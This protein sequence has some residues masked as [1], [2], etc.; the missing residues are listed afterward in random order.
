MAPYSDVLIETDNFSS[1]DIIISSV[2]LRI[3]D[4][5]KFL[6]WIGAGFGA[7]MNY[8][9]NN[10]SLLKREDPSLLMRNSRSIIVFL[11]N[12]KRRYNYDRRYGKIAKYALG[13]D[14][15]LFVI[16]IIKRYIENNHLFLDNFLAYTDTGPIS[17]K[18]ISSESGNGWIG[19]NSMFISNKI[20]SFTYL[21][22]A[23]TD[24]KIDN[25]RIPPTDLCGKCNRCI[26]SCP[27]GAINQDR[28][29][30]SRRCISYNTIENRGTIPATIASKM[31]DMLFGCDIC[32]DVCPW[33]NNSRYTEIP[34][35]VNYNYGNKAKI[36]ELAFIDKEQFTKIYRKSSI[37]RAGYLGIARNAAIAI[38]N[39]DSTD[40]ILKEIEKNFNDLRTKQI[41]ILKDQL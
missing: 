9:S 32:N 12:Y 17:E 23:I 16:N 27:T 25:F 41:K 1:E 15:H 10:S 38:Y 13:I 24:L 11:V 18:I 35:V 31:A 30:D 20:G 40:P 19:K 28:T 29:I 22:E 36:E 8:L 37:R 2:P 6:K 39:N 7:D 4:N 26:L 34:E 33:N 21:G 14:Y 5:S 3:Y